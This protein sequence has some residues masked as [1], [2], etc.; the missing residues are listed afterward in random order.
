MS[1]SQPFETSRLRF[2]LLTEADLDVVHRQFSDPDMCRWFS[3]PPATLAEARGIIE[4]YRAPEGQDHLRYGMF[5]KETGEFI[6]TCGYHYWDRDRRQVEVG[7]DI[8]KAHWRQ[9]Y[10]S[11]ALP[12]LLSL[13]FARLGV[14]HVYILVH[15]ENIASIASV[16]K[17]GF[18]DCEPCRQPDTEN[19]ICLKLSRTEWTARIAR[20]TP[21]QDVNAL[22]ARLLTGILPILGDQLVGMYLHGSLAAGEFD[23]RRSDIDFVVVTDGELPV[24]KVGE[25]RD[26]HAGIAAG[27]LRWATNHEGSYIP[28]RA[29][30]RHDPTDCV[31]PAVRVD[32]SFGRDR[33]GSEW[34]IQRHVIRERGITI[35]GPDPKSLIDPVS[36]DELRLAQRELLKEWWADRLDAPDYLRTSEYRAYAVLTMCRALYTLAHGAVVSKPAAASWARTTFGEQWGGLIDRAAAW[37]HGLD[38]AELEPVLAFIRFTLDRA[39]ET[40]GNAEEVR[41]QQHVQARD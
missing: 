14:D 21:Y 12:V 10:V 39:R 19:E 35:V 17:F 23:S 15:P 7:Y 11:E 3:E 33:H 16:R 13:C 36:P 34:V 2:R 22:L 1:L 20:A 4:H 18:R 9:G 37:R 6:G 28:R 31:F 38:M 24:D 27:D 32:G 40:A 41:G 29:I 26:M 30:R 8:W 25:L 5:A